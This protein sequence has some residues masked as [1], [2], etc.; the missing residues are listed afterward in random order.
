MQTE[1]WG[2]RNQPPL[3]RFLLTMPR[4]LGML[5]TY[6]KR[7]RWG[8]FCVPQPR[9]WGRLCTPAPRSLVRPGSI[10]RRSPAAAWGREAKHVA[11][12]LPEDAREASMCPLAQ[13][14]ERHA[15]RVALCHPAGR[16]RGVQPPHL[17]LV[18]APARSSL[19]QAS[20][21]PF[22]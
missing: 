16:P 19:V 20:T 4:W 5:R 21:C 15:A 17:L 13:P 22:K 7:G 11:P 2:A 1:L 3:P 9:C 18:R 14:E 8:S 6:K 12:A 10:D